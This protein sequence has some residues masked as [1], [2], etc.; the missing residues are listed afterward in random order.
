MILGIIPA[1]RH[2]H[3]S[4]LQVCK[5]GNGVAVQPYQLLSLRLDDISFFALPKHS[6]ADLLAIFDVDLLQITGKCSS[7]YTIDRTTNS[8]STSLPSPTS[9]PSFD[10]GTIISGVHSLCMSCSTDDL[11]T[12]FAIFIN[13]THLRA[14]VSRPGVPLYHLDV[15]C[16]DMRAAYTLGDFL[17]SPAAASVR[18]LNLD[19]IRLCRWHMPSK[20]FV[21]LR[22]A[23]C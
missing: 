8:D 14:E 3:L 6:F 4:R 22:T 7:P 5:N 21:L 19:L 18:S 9:T 13:S 12:W 2:L 23:H 16:E 10:L 11:A 20:F 17:R 1:L 15:H